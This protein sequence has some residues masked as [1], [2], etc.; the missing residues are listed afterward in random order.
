MDYIMWLLIGILIYSAIGETFIYLTGAYEDEFWLQVICMLLWPILV[1]IFVICCI[2]F[3]WEELYKKLHN[4]MKK[5]AIMPHMTR[6]EE[7]IK[8]LEL[9]GGVNAD[10]HKGNLPLE[11]ESAYYIYGDCTIQFAK[12]EYLEKLGYEIYTLEEYEQRSL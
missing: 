6:G 3:C 1:I 8:N 11:W 9:L 2:Y 10:E 4:N 5:I 12:I 7:V